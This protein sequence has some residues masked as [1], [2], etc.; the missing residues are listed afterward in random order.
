MHFFRE[1]II[2][3]A[4]MFAATGFVKENATVFAIFH[5]RYAFFMM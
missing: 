2:L 5:I 3:K 1:T 4:A